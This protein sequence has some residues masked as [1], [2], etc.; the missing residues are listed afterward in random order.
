MPS[1]D[2]RIDTYPMAEKVS[3]VNA[4]VLGVGTAVVGMEHAIVQTQ[5]ETSQKICNNLDSGFYLLMKSQI[6]QKIVA[7]YSKINSYVALMAQIK[8]SILSKTVQMQK[9]FLMIKKRY[10]KLFGELD[11]ELETRVREL[12]EPAMMIAETRK[13]IITNSF[14]NT[15]ATVLLSEKE[16]QNTKQFMLNARMK[17]KTQKS[18]D[19]LSNNVFN[20][21]TYSKKIDNMMKNQSISKNNELFVPVLYSR[22]KSFASE[23]A[24][25]NQTFV[26]NSLGVDAK[27]KAESYFTT[28]IEAN[29]VTDK[30]DSEKSLIKNEFAKFISSDSSSDRVKQTMQQLFEGSEL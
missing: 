2:C 26:S 21:E 17:T 30:K 1:Y 24:E 6:S 15:P 27:T 16:I 14:C 4:S 3:T 7:Q 19:A 22:M 20:T 23:N 11:R 5:I 10:T 18:L 12:D 29:I 13:A 8:K 28:A 9:D 25:F